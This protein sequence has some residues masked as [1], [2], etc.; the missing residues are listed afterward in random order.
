M[1]L[2]FLTA[3]DALI[4]TPAME[5]F[6]RALATFP[7]ARVIITA[8]EPRTWATSRR[9]RHPT[10]RVP[11]FHLLGFDAPMHA[12]DVEQSAMAFALWHRAVAASIPQSRLLV[13]DIA[14]MDDNELW[15]RLCKFVNRPRPVD[16]EGRLIPFPHER[17]GDDVRRHYAAMLARGEA[18]Q[19]EQ[20]PT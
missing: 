14:A 9:E 17:Y 12:L 18:S 11:L 8:R 15:S 2:R 5:I 20:N 7:H 1:D 3:T 19:S 13:L 10:D 16:T 6:Y 4:D